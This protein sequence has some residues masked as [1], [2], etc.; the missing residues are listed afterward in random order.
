M[1][2]ATNGRGRQRTQI[3]GKGSEA[4]GLECAA[5]GRG[6]EGGAAGLVPEHARN[7]KAS[8]PVCVEKNLLLAVSVCVK[9]N[10][11]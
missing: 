8:V 10:L 9:M 11:C 7:R 2:G 1:K 3:R 6:G 5:N 4:L